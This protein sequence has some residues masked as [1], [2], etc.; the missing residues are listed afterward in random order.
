MAKIENTLVLQDAM[1]PVLQAVIRSLEITVSTLVGLDQVSSSTAS[2][3]LNDFGAVENVMNATERAVDSAE[4]A[5]SD[6]GIVSGDSAREL[7]ADF[8]AVG[9]AVDLAEKSV[10]SAGKAVNG[11]GKVSGDATGKLQKGFSSAEKAINFVEKNL[12]SASKSANSA[13]KSVDSVSKSV[14]SASKSSDAV[15]KAFDSVTKS[16][17]SADKV[18]ESFSKAISDAEEKVK[19]LG[20]EVDEVPKKQDAVFKGFSGWEKGIIVANQAIGI[21]KSTIGK[22]GLI[23]VNKAFDRMDT[24]TNFSRTM[25]VLTGDAQMA[26]AALESLKIVTSGTAYGL[27]T[28]AKATQG[29][30]TRGMGLKTAIKQVEVWSDA[31][32]FYGD[33][34]SGQL[35]NV[36]DAIGKMVSKGRVDMNQLDRLTGAGINAVGIYAQA[37]GQAVGEVQDKLSKGAIG[38]ADFVS[39]I[40]D[41]MENGTNGVLSISGAAKKAGNTWA[42]TFANMR[43]AGTRG[44][45]GLIEAIDSGLESAGLGAIKENLVAIGPIVEN[46]LKSAGT[47]IGEFIGKLVPI[48]TTIWNVLSSIGGVLG[49]VSSSVSGVLGSVINSVATILSSICGWISEVIFTLAPLGE[50][51]WNITVSVAGL[52]ESVASNWDIIQPI[53]IGIATLY[54]GIKIAIGLYNVALMVKKGLEL[55]SATITA[56]KTGATIADTSATAAATAAQWGLNAAMLANPITWIVILII[57]LIAIIVALALWFIKLWKTN[58]DFRA[59]VIKIWNSILAFFDQI[60]IFFMTVGYGIADAFGW[61]KVT[62]LQ[63]LQDLAN[64]AIDIINKMIETLNE[65]PGVSIDTISQVTF[66]TIAALEEEAARQNRAAD[67]ED[68]KEAAA[69]KAAERDAKLQEDIEKWQREAQEK[70]DGYTEDDDGSPVEDLLEKLLGSEDSGMPDSGRDYDS[71]G[72][73]SKIDGGKLDSVDKV[74]I[75]DEDLK[76]LK[77]ISKVDYVNRYTT[78]RP[79]VNA[80]FGDIRETADIN[81]LMGALE[82]TIMELNSSSL[83]RG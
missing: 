25:G 65:I 44:V 52:F 62:S 70:E 5:V 42:T 79:V 1:S 73:G 17:E 76:Y 45:I 13:S 29:F 19:K 78:L 28:A 11:L 80:T 55:A 56:L 58:I 9:N 23:D 43:A 16:V 60:P 14:D 40:T 20:D 21:L 67:L 10:D 36:T 8:S 83:D 54:G 68:A 34:T 59:G 63:I 50:M 6:L 2:K 31:V 71:G 48:G 81:E 12:D 82:E 4:R 77:D 69:D 66:G 53:L 18:F 32:A 51:L 33:G 27:D 7:Q 24:M 30:V 57:A 47:W 75:S 22:L 49:E 3:L 37:T 72:S 26:E 74:G 61:A 15:E 39:T 64:G 38:S 41:A 46:A 35:E